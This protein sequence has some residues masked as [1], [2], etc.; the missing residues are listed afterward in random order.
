MK[1]Y[2]RR[3]KWYKDLF[4]QCNILFDKSTQTIM[5]DKRWKVIKYFMPSK[6]MEK[7][8]AIKEENGKRKRLGIG[9][10][11]RKNSEDNYWIAGYVPKKHQDKGYGIYAGIACI[12]ELFKH[13]PE[14]TVYSASRSSNTRAVRT[15]T[16]FGFKILVEDDKHFESSITKEQFDNDFVRYIKKR[17]NI[18]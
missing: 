2:A 17:S 13:H 16:S 12:N 4:F 18:T 5:F 10:F 8:I 11:I 1:I 15:T 6:F 3:Y 7:Y 9:K 14:C